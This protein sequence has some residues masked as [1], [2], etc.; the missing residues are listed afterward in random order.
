MRVSSPAAAER[1]RTL[2][3]LSVNSSCVGG[4]AERV[5]T[6]LHAQYLAR[7]IESWLALGNRDCD[8]PNAVQIPTD[9]RRNAWARLLL[10]WSA[11][12]SDRN[13][14]P[15]DIAWLVA[16]ALRVAAQPVRWAR[17]LSGREDFDFPETAHL[18]ELIPRVPDILHLHNIHGAYFDIRALPALSASCPTIITMHDAWLL[19]GHCAHPF[20]CE[21]FKTGCGDCPHLDTYVPLYA[22]R[23]DV[24]WT[25]KRDAISRSRLSLACP[26][27]WLLDRVAES[28]VLSD[29]VQARVVPNGVD[30][31]V[32]APGD[33]AQA[34]AE[35]GL[36]AER[37]I[38]CF[39][40]HGLKTNQFKNV[41][42]VREALRITSKSER[43]SGLMLLALGGEGTSESIDGIEIVGTPF[44]DD[45]E[46]LA[47]YYR[48]ADVYVHAARAD[49]LPLAIIEAMACGTPVVATNVGGIPEIVDDGVTGVLVEPENAPAFAEAILALLADE[50]RRAAFSRAGV[51]RVRERFTLTRQVEA[52]LGW[53]QELIEAAEDRA[54]TGE[55]R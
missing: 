15:G 33:R 18:L 49:N 2:T 11:G 53:Y 42:L 29:T 23:S 31:S 36:P 22:D 24:N 47:R 39:A 55:A 44:V 4:G 41:E 45:P 50:P 38:L 51:E 54:N 19:T 27:R 7:G 9:E 25:V 17:V 46:L 37:P 8:V 28:G 21:R 12:V 43:A 20:E 30:T 10:G 52:Y 26:S 6:D 32:F 14:R 1:S 40:G 5:M 34:R 16:R 3:V 35:L 48:A 13:A